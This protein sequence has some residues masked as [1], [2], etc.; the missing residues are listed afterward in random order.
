MESAIEK[1]MN[2]KQGK[3]SILKYCMKVMNLVEL[4]NLKDQAVKT[5]FFCGLYPKDQD[6]IIV[7][8]ALKN[9]AELMEETLK[10]YLKRSA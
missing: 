6:W 1:L 7:L 3:T 5:Y 2:L 4:V 8:N 10:D 9:E